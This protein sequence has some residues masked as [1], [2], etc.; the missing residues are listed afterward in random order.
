MHKYT[1][2]HTH[3]HSIAILWS[4]KDSI[5]W[6][7]VYIH[8]EPCQPDSAAKL[9]CLCS[10]TLLYLQVSIPGL[11]ICLGIFYRLF[12]LLEEAVNKFD[13]QVAQDISSPQTSHT[14]FSQFVNAIHKR[15]T[16]MEKKDALQQRTTLMDEVITLAA[17]NESA[18]L[19]INPS[20][21]TSMIEEAAQLR[22]SVEETVNYAW[23]VDPRLSEH[24]AV[25]ICEMFG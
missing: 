15:R 19:T 23:T 12:D 22:E 24:S 5:V 16:L 25:Q 4:T 2:K 11:H 1:H 10:F 13:F 20:L 17:V 6:C 18:S 8:F 14:S 7:V 9:S 21:V 3:T